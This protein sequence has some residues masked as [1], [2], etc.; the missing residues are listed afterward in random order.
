MTS[1]RIVVCTNQKNTFILKALI[2]G[3]REKKMLIAPVLFN[4]FVVILTKIQEE[5][6]ATNTGCSLV[7]KYLGV[8]RAIASKVIITGCMKETQH[9]TRTQISDTITYDR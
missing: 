2:K 9:P 3:S 4:F 1:W 5:R 6:E 8:T 7:L